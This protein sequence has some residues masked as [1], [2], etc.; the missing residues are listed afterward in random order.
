MELVSG[1]LAE[2]AT[3]AGGGD[4]D[5]D[6][7]PVI[8][9]IT[10]ATP[11]SVSGAS[12]AFPVFPVGTLLT[13]TPAEYEADG[14]PVDPEVVA[15]EW[16]SGG[17]VV[18]TGL[19]YTP[20]AAMDL[21]FRERV[22]HPDTGDELVGED[23]ARSGQMTITDETVPAA[24]SAPGPGDWSIASVE[25]SPEGQLETFRPVIAFAGAIDAAPYADVQWTTDSQVPARTDK[26]ETV[27]PVAPA[28]WRG[29][30][31]PAYFVVGTGDQTVDVSGD[32]VFGAVS[33]SLVSPPAGVSI[34]AGTGIITISTA[35]A[36]DW[37]TIT[38]RATSVMGG[39]SADVTV[40]LAV[41]D[42]DHEI[43]L[44]NS[45]S[46]WSVSP[47]SGDVVVI[48]AGTSSE[49]WW[50]DGWDGVSVYAYPGE[51]VTIDASGL[52]ADNAIDIGDA[53]GISLYGLTILG[54]AGVSFGIGGWGATG[55]TIQSCD[56][57]GFAR[58]AIYTGWNSNAATRPHFIRY[59]SL[60]G[61]VTENAAR[62]WSSGWGSVIMLD[63]ADGSVVER[64][65]VF[66]SYGEGIRALRSNGITITENTVHDCY[67]ANI[68]LDNVQGAD[69]SANIIWSDDS[70]YYRDWGSGA[71]PAISALAANE[72]Y[73][74]ETWLEQASAG[75]VVEGNHI[76]SGNVLPFYD[77]SYGAGGGAG[78][79]SSFAP[80]ETFAGSIGPLVTGGDY[81]TGWLNQATYDG[82]WHLFRE[83]QVTRRASQF[84]IRWRNASD[85]EWSDESASKPIGVPA[86]PAAPQP[87]VT[88]EDALA[89]G[90]D[91]ELILTATAPADWG[92][93]TTGVMQ[94]QVSGG[95]WADFTSPET[96]TFP[97]AQWGADVVV[98]LRSV[99]DL[100]AISASVTLSQTIPGEIGGEILPGQWARYAVASQQAWSDNLDGYQPGDASLESG[101]QLQWCHGGDRSPVNRNN[102]A[103]IQ[104]VAL[105]WVSRNADAPRPAWRHSASRGAVSRYSVSL[106]FDPEQGERFLYAV[107][108][109]RGSDGS[110]NDGSVIMVTDN[111]GDDYRIAATFPIIEGSSDHDYIWRSYRKL[112]AYD[113]NDFSRW[114]FVNPWHDVHTSSDRG[115][116]W[117][118]RSTFPTQGNMGRVWHVEVDRSNGDHVWAGCE[119]GLWKST[120]WGT[121]FSKLTPSGLPAGMITSMVFNP[122]D[123]DDIYVVVY[124]VGLFRT[125]NGGASFAR[126]TTPHNRVG[127]VAISPVD[128][129]HA[130][131][132]DVR[133][134]LSGAQ[135]ASARSMYCSNLLS[136][137]PS[138]SYV[139]VDDT[140][141]GWDR[142]WVQ[143]D[144]WINGIG[145][146]LSIQNAVLPSPVVADRAVAH[147]T[148]AMWHIEG[149]AWTNASDGFDCLASGDQNQ[150]NVA[151]DPNNANRAVFGAFDHG[152]FTT[153]S[154]GDWWEHGSAVSSGISGERV[155]GSV[156]VNPERPNTVMMS[157]GLYNP[158]DCRVVISTDFGATAGN[159]FRPSFFTAN[160]KENWCS[161][162][163]TI[164]R[165]GFSRSG[166]SDDW[167]VSWQRWQDIDTSGVFAGQGAAA[168]H[169]NAGVFAVAPSNG[170]VLW[171]SDGLGTKLLRTT[172]MGQ[173][174]A[175]ATAEFDCPPFGTN[176]YAPSP[177]P[178]PTDDG[179]MFWW[180]K[181]EGL[182]RFK[183]G[184]G[185]TNY[186]NIGADPRLRVQRIRIDRNDPDI[187][188]L[189][190]RNT[191]YNDITTIPGASTVMVLRSVNGPA[192]PFEDVTAGLPRVI[193]I[194][195]IE[196]DPHTGILYAVGTAG[197]YLLAP[198]YGSARFDVLADRFG[199][200]GG[201]TPGG[202]GTDPEPEP[203]TYPPLAASAVAD[204]AGRALAYYVPG[205]NGVATN[206]TAFFGPSNTTLALAVFLG[207]TSRIP[208]LLQCMRKWLEGGTEPDS[209]GAYSA[210]HYS[211][212]IATI[213]IAKQIPAVWNDELT[214]TER[215]KLSD[216]VEFCGYGCA[217]VTSYLYPNP[218]VALNDTGTAYNQE[219]NA[220][221]T[222]AKGVIVAMAA[223]FFGTSTFDT[224]LANFDYASVRSR[225]SANGFTNMYAA[226]GPRGGLTITQLE[227]VIS[228][229]GAGWKCWYDENGVRQAG[230]GVTVHQYGQLIKREVWGNC[231]NA[232]VVR[233]IGTG[234]KGINIGGT[235]WGTMITTAA[236][237]DARLAAMPYPIGTTGG[238]AEFDE[239]DG[240]G[241]RC[242]AQYV[243]GGAR[244][245]VVAMVAL[246]CAGAWSKSGG[247]PQETMDRY[248]IGM[249][250]LE[251][252]LY[253]TGHRDHQLGGAAR[254]W[255]QDPDKTEINR[256]GLDYSFA[257]AKWVAAWHGRPWG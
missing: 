198:P 238:A 213:L 123:P 153:E 211:Y 250:D 74:G 134:D 227:N 229:N 210:Q 59:N 222:V 22:L 43:D 185:V 94:R 9:T 232:Q 165:F 129:N 104:D 122:A 225:M 30:V 81:T 240:G 140:G 200:M 202:G 223:I 151:W 103:M 234:G 138:W 195:S 125:I 168:T 220:N 194:R 19:T 80:N 221:H 45:E 101:Y 41:I 163:P 147:S 28:L 174:W 73:P 39:G 145:I 76:L 180:K 46:Y 191:S 66:D 193:S 176:G 56:I 112:L 146:R 2:A 173:T 149:A 142:G 10:I 208:R 54:G 69:V 201:G 49:V 166:R 111:M 237:E 169:R 150:S 115:E 83:A 179:A 130:W 124:C 218:G 60:H 246:I 113:P 235:M 53:S 243:L 7:D 120:N 160:Q 154:G 247:V 255:P 143:G 209:A 219:Y 239:S 17:S 171:A 95:A 34:D 3:V 133:S 152:F 47:S 248:L 236:N 5:P 137:S 32:L 38:A 190:A 96:L 82:G 245:G 135:V 226:W 97:E 159:S 65:H 230:G 241:A 217:F 33:W 170:S 87:P 37:A 131:L 93:G 1:A 11:P 126:V 136:G 13:A 212:V 172:N 253:V 256:F 199:S 63:L 167:G 71:A 55:V 224:M 252:K 144:V 90:D 118:Q 50:I 162:H 110:P 186:S 108:G 12:G 206:G 100:G 249:A 75:L 57:S 52:T 64:N 4:P 181:G 203:V 20:G 188:Y 254:H 196:L 114:I 29:W 157:R 121:T 231:F 214:E 197:T 257:L 102:A 14:D 18:G 161:W 6:P 78:A 92:G 116:S 25:W 24:P 70:D 109:G 85:G 84:R 156:S 242:S 36:L 58:G 72:L 184:V 91:G 233:G 51:T 177:C 182:F 128:R 207:D 105:A 16:L 79:G 88:G 44:S 67:S 139:T 99:N 21:I 107:S 141:G 178:H 205:G 164:G 132:M 89:Q 106:L 187:M 62:S 183:Q 244:P 77:G 175:L 48:R 127:Q 251:Y 98:A 189:L 61:C 86:V 117:S 40:E 31:D 42:P 68:Y 26:W 204:A 192:G 228:G 27:V 35:A 216:I 119:T 215:G 158:G 15:Y 8:R 155:V 148:T 23:A